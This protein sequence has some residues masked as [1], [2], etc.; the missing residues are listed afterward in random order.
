MVVPVI[1]LMV[2]AAAKLA[3]VV[4]AATVKPIFAH[5]PM[6]HAEASVAFVHGLLHLQWCGMI[7]DVVWRHQ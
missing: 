4:A 1:E 5:S 3:L 7:H 2:E 6:H